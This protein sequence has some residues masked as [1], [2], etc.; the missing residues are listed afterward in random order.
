MKELIARALCATGMPALARRRRR[1]LLPILMYHGVVERPLSP[2][3][4][5]QLDVARFRRQME[6]VARRY[7]VLPLSEALEGLLGGTLPDRSLSITFDDGYRNVRTTA[8]PVLE[9]LGLPAT[10]YLVTD[11]VGTDETLWPD[12]L[13]LA[14]ARSAAADVHLPDLGLVKRRLDGPDARASAYATSVRVLKGLPQ[15]EKDARLDALL[16]ALGRAAPEDPAEFRSLSWDDV[17]AM[18]RSGRF[19]WG[20]HSTRHEILAR[21]PDGHVAKAIGRSH[22]E[23]ATRTGVVPASF[24]YPNGRAMD[25]DDRSRSALTHLGVRFALSTIEG[26]AAPA[27]DPLA[28]PRLSIGSDLSFARFRL[29]VSGA[30]ESLRG[31]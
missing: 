28:L 1:R 12:R 26:F 25:F 7:R 11:V 21:M 18:Q 20:G 24:A 30:L 14:F 9:T 4:W 16:D 23:V 15:A 2:R 17:A 31:R 29:L 22:E 19:E 3:C 6:W 8:A 5:H 27:S 13:Y 10:V